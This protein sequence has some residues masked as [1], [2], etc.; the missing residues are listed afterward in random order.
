MAGFVKSSF[1]DGFEIPE[2]THEAVKKQLVK[3]GRVHA[4]TKTKSVTDMPL[5]ERLKYIT[6]EVYKVLGRYKN[7]VKVIDTDEEFERY[8]DLAVRRGYLAL[9][10]ETNRSIDPLTCKLMGMCLYVPNTRPVYAPVSHC[11]A[12][13]DILLKNNISHDCIKRCIR[14]LNSSGT[15][16][17]YHNGKFDIRVFHGV[18]GIYPNIWWDTMIAS[19]L[20]DENAMAKLKT[21]YPLHVDPTVSSYDIETLFTGLPYEWIPVEIFA[22][23]SAIDSYDT[24]FLQQSQQRKFEEKGMERLYNLLMNVEMPVVNVVAR[25]EDNGVCVDREILS[26][27]DKKMKDEINDVTTKIFEFLKPYERE[28]KY[29]QENGKLDNP[30][31]LSSPQQ[32]PIIIYDILKLKS[33]NGRSTDKDT[34]KSIDSEFT[35]LLLRYRHATKLVSSFTEPLPSFIS[36]RDDKLHASFNQLGREENNVRTGR[37]SSTKPNLQ[38][39]PSHYGLMRMMF[40]ASDEY[41]NIKIDSD[42]VANTISVSSVQEVLTDS[43]WKFAKDIAIGDKLITDDSGE[44]VTVEGV[45]E[46]DNNYV[47][48]VSGVIG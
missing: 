26:R 36:T 29:Y 42:A 6:E 48:I 13:T 2:V 28:I 40:R 11:E 35:K 19:Q 20:L 14:K 30:I 45:D 44:F 33:E 34:L 8:V 9:D 39:I 47:I 5:P 43:G 27:I 38:Q 7:F 10:T 23:Y 1:L 41:E 17:I 18:E 4:V 24:Y 16:I 31:N 12:G 32:L 21:Q 25:M 15:K 37:F 46:D 22:L 3:L